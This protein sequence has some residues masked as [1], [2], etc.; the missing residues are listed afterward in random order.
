MQQKC[1]AIA[2]KVFCDCSKS[3][4]RL[5]KKCFAIAEKVFCDC[6]KS[7]CDC[8]KSVLQ[9]QQK[10]FEIAEK[11]LVFFMIDLLQCIV[12]K[13]SEMT[14]S[15]ASMPPFRGLSASSANRR[16]TS[17]P[18]YH[19]FRHKLHLN[20]LVG[21]I[22]IHLYSPLPY[23]IFNNNHEGGAAAGGAARSLYVYTTSSVFFF[24][25][26][27]LQR[28]YTTSS[29]FFFFFFSLLRRM[30]K[31]NASHASTYV[32]SCM[33]CVNLTQL[34][35]HSSTSWR[36]LRLSFGFRGNDSASCH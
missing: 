14:P 8:S 16:P 7:V 6:S 36:T 1:F 35:S 5:Q 34:Y 23:T 4:L 28:M 19:L 9:L 26:F 18:K 15:P 17:L 20:L 21:V 32:F 10:C 24:N 22:P 11:V 3:V 29:A 12:L 31:K 2:A 27:I 13:L 33:L 25:S 30:G